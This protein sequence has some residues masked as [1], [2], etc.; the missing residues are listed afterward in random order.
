MKEEETV[1]TGENAEA[2]ESAAPAEAVEKAG[3]AEQPKK[4]RKG[5]R[6]YLSDIRRGA[7]GKYVYT[8]TCYTY[9]KLNPRLYVLLRLWALTIPAVAACVV[10]GCLNAPFTRD[11]WY[12]LAPLGFAFVCA[13]SVTWAVGRITGNK[14]VLRSYVRKQTFGAIPLRC[15]FMI[16]FAAV[17]LIGAAIYMIVHGTS[18][19]TLTGAVEDRTAACVVYLIMQAICIACGVLLIVFVRSLRWQE[20]LKTV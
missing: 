2:V 3:T 12:V 13:G 17:S 14:S 1:R 15:G 4:K 7:N 5:R 20:T 6:A 11:T 9:D 8:G 16:G 10:S 18:A 19:V